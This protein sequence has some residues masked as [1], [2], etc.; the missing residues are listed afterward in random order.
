M[1]AGQFLSQ[2]IVAHQRMLSGN[3]IPACSLNSIS[4]TND[5]KIIIRDYFQ[6]ESMLPST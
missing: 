1:R 5:D 4:M 2:S 6:K 3:N